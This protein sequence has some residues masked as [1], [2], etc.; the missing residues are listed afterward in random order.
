[1][2][3]NVFPFDFSGFGHFIFKNLISIKKIKEKKIIYLN[4]KIPLS[5]EVKLSKVYHAKEVPK[6]C[7]VF[8]GCDFQ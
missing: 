1:M 2:A 8:G 5:F 3:R 4:V 6:Y 7:K